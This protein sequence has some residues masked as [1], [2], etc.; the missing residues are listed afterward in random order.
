MQGR[1]EDDL[2]TAD[3]AGRRPGAGQ[4]P[5]AEA[6]RDLEPVPDAAEASPVSIDTDGDRGT[7]EESRL[8]SSPTAGAGG[9]EPLFPP[10]AEAADALR[11]GQLERKDEDIFPPA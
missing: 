7:S 6:D 11:R 9:R 1:R 8:P 10:Q 2:T 5:D 4:D 3:L